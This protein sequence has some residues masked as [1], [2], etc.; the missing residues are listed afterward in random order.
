M[1]VLL[2]S[3]VA[4]TPLSLGG[5]N[6]VVIYRQKETFRRQAQLDAAANSIRRRRRSAAATDTSTLSLSFAVSNATEGVLVY[7]HSSDTSFTVLY[8]RVLHYFLFVRKSQ[9]SSTGVR[10][11]FVKLLQ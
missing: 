8:V 5:P 10:A 2:W 11:G 9:R 6:S 1:F 4:S 7:S 3:S